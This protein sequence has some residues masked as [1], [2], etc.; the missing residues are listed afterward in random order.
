MVDICF[1]RLLS[2]YLLFSAFMTLNSIHTLGQDMEEHTIYDYK[3]VLAYFVEADYIG[4][5]SKVDCT[6]SS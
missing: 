6:L 1:I 3:Y 4:N 2:T 5:P